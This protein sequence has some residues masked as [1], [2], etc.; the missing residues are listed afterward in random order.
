MANQVSLITLQ[1]LYVIGLLSYKRHILDN[2]VVTWTE[3][4]KGVE[5]VKFARLITLLDGLN[6]FSSLEHT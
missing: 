5:E 1:I 3:L 2:L 6:T 4:E